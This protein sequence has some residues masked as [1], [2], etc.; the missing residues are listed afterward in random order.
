MFTTA[1]E[2][3]AKEVTAKMAGIDYLLYRQHAVRLKNGMVKDLSR[4]G[5]NLNKT[6]IVDDQSSNYRSNRDNGI[7][8]L[9]WKGDKMDMQLDRIKEF[10]L[11]LAQMECPDVK[12]EIPVFKQQQFK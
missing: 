2:A 10:L 1:N 6:V 5:R 3:Y 4:L 11:H 9:S 7:K 12:K 8:I